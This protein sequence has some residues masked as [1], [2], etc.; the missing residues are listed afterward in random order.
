MGVR[1]SFGL[2]VGPL[3]VERGWPVA[4]F[5]FAL[6]LQNLLWGV[7]QPFAGA[8]ADRFGV[9]KV[10]AA[11]GLLYAAGLALTA[12]VDGASAAVWGAG[13][14][15]GLGISAA[16]FAVLLGAV[17]QAVPPERRSM[18][19]GL[20]SAGGSFGQMA[21]VPVAHGLIT[22]QGVAD[23]M[24]VMAALALLMAPLALTL[25]GGSRRHAATTL[26]LGEAIAEASRH[27]GYRLLTAGFFVCGFQIVFIGVHLPSYLA[28]CHMPPAVGASALTVIGLF[29][30][31]GTWAAGWLGGRWRPKYILSGIYI[32]RSVIIVLFL[33]LPKTETS[34]LL[35]SAAIGI[36]W[37]STVPLTSGLVATVFGPR[38]MA[39]LFGIV[40]LSHQVGAFLGTWMGGALFD[41]MGSYDVVWAISVVLGVVAAV[42][43]LPISDKAIRAEV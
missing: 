16:S 28:T 38:Y 41:L 42:M 12:W 29:N 18:A 39:T 35:F 11:G 24:L 23:A 37:L 20:A 2:F 27:S 32:A 9:P 5:A 1:Q 30:M 26:S 13:V 8:A 21:M 31:I 43:H 3:S 25:R 7:A 4:T 15:V 6:A 10:V 14:L 36:L 34:V 33:A 17:A 40:F 22:T 19:L